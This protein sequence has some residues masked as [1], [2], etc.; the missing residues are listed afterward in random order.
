LRPVPPG[1]WRA[2]APGCSA[3]VGAAGRCACPSRWRPGQPGVGGQPVGGV[4]LVQ[5]ADRDQ[6][7]GAEAEPEPGHATDHPGQ[8][9]AAKP[10]GDLAV[11]GGDPHPEIGRLLGERGHQFGRHLLAS[12][13]QA[14]G[15]GRGDG[16]LG[17]V[18]GRAGTHALGGQQPA[19]AAHPSASDRRRPLVAGQ[20]HQPAALAGRLGGAFQRGADRGQV[21]AQPVEGAGAVSD[22]VGPLGDQQAQLGHQAVTGAQHR[23]VVAHPGLVGDDV[24]V[25][26]VSLALSA[27]AG[28]SLVDRPARQISHR[29][30][31]TKQHRQQQRGLGGSQVDGP[32]Q[33]SGQLVDLAN[34]PGDLLLVV[35]DPARQHH[36]ALGVLGHHPV[37]RLAD[38]HPN[39]RH[40]E[41]HTLP[42]PGPCTATRGP[43]RRQLLKSAT[44]RR[45]QSAARGV[46]AGQAATPLDPRSPAGK[47]NPSLTRPARLQQARTLRRSL[48]PQAT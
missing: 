20:Q 48:P 5:V 26:G 46:Q 18:L 39:P 43:L 15:A 6:Q 12:Q 40:L 32:D 36:P 31:A 24:G 3:P 4:D 9:V 25:A 42:R 35:G 28:R 7:L 30:A 41:H 29:L 8:P 44:P 1:T 16:G 33:P 23:Q 11:E 17:Q 27:V 21:L 19:Q 34:D 22:Q 47:V 45:S 2:A 38:I 10:A 13:P 14:L 37:V